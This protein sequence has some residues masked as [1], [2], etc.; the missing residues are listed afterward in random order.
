MSSN[1]N[2]NKDKISFQKWIAVFGIVLF[3]AKIIAWKL[4][5]SDAVFSDAMESIVNVI[6]A[7]MGLYSLHLAS[8]PKD[9]DHPYGHGK[10]EFVTAGIEGAL[11]AIAGIMIIYEGINSLV[12]GRILN[13]LDWGIAIIAATAVINYFL[14]YISIKKGE[15][16]SSL[17]LIA[18]GKH[19]QSDTITT[20]GVVISLII[21]YFTK[22]YWIDSVVALIFGFYII[23]VGYKI[24]R[25]SLSGIMDEQDPEL[26]NNIIQLLENN[27]ETEWIDI[28][29][30]KIQQFGASLH[31]DA[32]I[33]LPWYYSLRDAHKEMEKVILL[34]A[35][36]TIRTVE[37]NFHM[38]DCKPISCPICQIMDCPVRE[39]PFI[40]RVEWT[41]ENVTNV[42]K[43][44][45]E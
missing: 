35:K 44:T 23:F 17:V 18:S 5:N 27:R 33:T 38:D 9:E 14:G 20:L 26:L 45:A 22:I 34:L 11:I 25:K 16:E 41:A 1:K 36:N 3:V 28:H 2:I 7:F 8:K 30:M 15:K 24:I 13:D 12:T 31:I 43:H 32:H 40:R 39:Q 4:T 19:L 37:F 21:V 6:S 29:N 10:V 42:D